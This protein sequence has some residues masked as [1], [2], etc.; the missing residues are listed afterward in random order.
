MPL[1]PPSFADSVHNFG[2]LVHLICGR[3]TIGNDVP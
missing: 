1:D 3:P 2:R